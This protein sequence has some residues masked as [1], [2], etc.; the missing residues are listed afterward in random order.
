[1]DDL[2]DLALPDLLAGE[3]ERLRAGLGSSWPGSLSLMAPI[4][5]PAPSATFPA[6]LPTAFLA[7]VKALPASFLVGNL[8]FTA[9]TALPAASDALEAASLALSPR[10]SLLPISSLR[11]C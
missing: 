1:M 4:R 3:V 7:P 9:S 2:D 11:P 10:S 6:A 5:P 8:S